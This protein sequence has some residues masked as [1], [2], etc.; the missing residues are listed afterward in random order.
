MASVVYPLGFDLSNL[1]QGFLSNFFNR[2]TSNQTTTSNQTNVQ[3]TIS[4]N[5]DIQYNVASDG[6]SIS[7]KKEQSVA[8]NPNLTP[9]IFQ[10]PATNQGASLPSSSSS[11]SDSPFS[12]LTGNLTG[13]AI[14][15]VIAFLGYKFIAKGK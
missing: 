13:V 15:G 6:S 5:Y 9:Q 7:T 3:N 8:Q 2:N 14:I 1:G 11:G 12:I 10:I 4:R